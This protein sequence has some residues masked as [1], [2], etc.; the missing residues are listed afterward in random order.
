MFITKKSKEY[1]KR[2]IQLSSKPRIL[3]I[4]VTNK[5]NLQCTICPKKDGNTE[6]GFIDMDFFKKIINENKNVLSGQ[7]VWLHFSGE[8]LLHPDLSKIIK[9]LN[10]NNIRTMLSTNAVLLNKKKSLD[11]LDAGLDY[12]VFSVD[13]YSKE[14]Y[15]NIRIG[16]KFDE[17]K[18]NI[19]NF[20]KIKEEG[21]FKT[22]TQVQFVELKTNTKEV[23]DF[24][25]EWKKTDVNHIN[26]KSFCTRA[27]RVENIKNF[28]LSPDIHKQNIKRRPC[29]YL[30]ETLI[31]L[32][33]GKVITCCQD[34]K[35]ELIVGDLKKQTL[36]EIWNSPKL[37]E[38]RRRQTKGDF[39]MEPCAGCGDWKKHS[40][41]YFGTIYNSFFKKIKEKM[42]NKIIKDEGI[43]IIINHK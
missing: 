7:A 4:E 34:L 13:G 20:L 43:N 31:V 2:K 18:K 39:S 25:N 6:L 24:I 3:N 9:L 40:V 35:S 37:Q 27:G 11:L 1:I 26:V 12:I 19:L 10:E 16:A 23:K 41:F 36:L 42:F 17:V 21:G 29:F 30:W 32:W 8:P 38:I 5:C 14:I 28:H 15:E 22:L 33:N